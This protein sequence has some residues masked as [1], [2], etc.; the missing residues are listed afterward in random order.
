MSDN[1]DLEFLATKSR[2][3][4]EKQIASYR[5]KHS[6]AGI[7][8]GV[9][10]LFIPYFINGLE[11]AYLWVQ[12]IALL[13]IGLLVI[14]I[15]IMLMVLRTKKLFHFFSPGKF[16]ELVNTS[17]EK[18][19]LYEIG[20]NIDSYKDNKPIDESVNKAFNNGIGVTI[21]A[22]I[23]SV[24]LLITNSYY[25]PEQ[26]PIKVQIQNCTTMAQ[27]EDK[28]ETPRVIPTVPPGDRERLNEGVDRPQRQAPIPPKP[29][30]KK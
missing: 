17:Y 7:I 18:I 25:H 11:N 1:K 16:N 10:T 6:N 21:I 2:E 27:N 8:I 14:A 19:L 5:Q 3:M 26:K 13:P 22:I 28:P 4:V 12:I 29:V 30:T 23:I 20:S 9:I 24:S 15:I